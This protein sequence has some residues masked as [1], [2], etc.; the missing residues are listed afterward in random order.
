MCQ[1][2]RIGLKYLLAAERRG[3]QWLILFVNGFYILFFFY[4]LMPRMTDMD[5]KHVLVKISNRKPVCFVS[6]PAEHETDLAR[7]QSYLS[8]IFSSVTLRAFQSKLSVR[9]GEDSGWISEKRNRYQI[10]VF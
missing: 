4:L 5:L 7:K 2:P 1:A 8:L 9:N 10:K 6:D 3:E